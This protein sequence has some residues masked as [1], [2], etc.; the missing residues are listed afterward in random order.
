[1]LQTLHK[2][3]VILSHPLA[4]HARTKTLFRIASWQ[5]RSRLQREIIVPWIAGQKLIV[6][7]GMTGATGNIYF[8]LHEFTDMMFLLHFLRRDDVFLDI[9]ANVGTYSV[10]ASGVCKA[11]THAFEPDPSALVAL[12]RNVEI[13][14]LQDLVTVHSEALGASDR[15]V[16]FTIGLD[17]ANRI[18]TSGD[19]GHYRLVQQKQLDSTVGNCGPSFAKLDVEGYEEE[20]LRGGQALLAETSFRA[21]ELETV[22]PGAQGILSNLRFK[23][24][25]YD[26]FTRRLSTEPVGLPSSNALFIKDFSF[27]ADRIESSPKVQVLDSVI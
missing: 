20:V 6:K 7:R 24:A 11:T 27:V 18:A 21:I 15:E 26:P 3:R 9:G 23:R 14:N 12:R 17:T 16:G 4:R 25:F 8:G 13:N 22:T 5:L 10:L 2:L 19:D 1:M